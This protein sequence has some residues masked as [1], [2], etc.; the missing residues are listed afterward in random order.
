MKRFSILIS[1]AVAL[2]HFVVSIYIVGGAVGA[3]YAQERGVPDHSAAWNFGLWIWDTGPMLL[4]PFFQPLRPIHILYLLAPWSV[5]IGA[6]C[7]F[8]MPHLWRL[9]RQIA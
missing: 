2:L 4:V 6:C 1:A 3:S 7:G 8:L 5:L 9:R